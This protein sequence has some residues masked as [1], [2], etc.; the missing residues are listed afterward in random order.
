MSEPRREA[1]GLRRALRRDGLRVAALAGAIVVVW[2]VAYGRTNLAAWLVPV[3]Y[4][5]DSWHTLAVLKAAADGHVVP[6]HTL[7]VDELN[8]PYGAGWNGFLRQH[9]LQY[10]FAGRLAR[11]I[12][13]FPASNL[14][15]LL[16]PMLA[17]VSLFAVS[18][19][20]RARPEWALAAACVFAFAPFLFYRSLPHLTL[21]FYWPIPI[22]ILVV[23][24]AFGRRAIVLG[25]RRFWIS[26][27][28][29]FACGLQNIYFAG[30]LAQFLALAALVQCP[31][32]RRLGG[33][34]APLTLL[35]IL[36]TSLLLDNLN[37]LLDAAGNGGGL[38]GIVRPY[39]NLERFALKPLELVLPPAGSGLAPWRPLSE[40]YQQ[41]ALYRGE[42]GSAYLGLAGIAALGWLAV[43][44]A[45]GF[46]R[47]P[48]A[49]VPAAFLAVSWIV[50]YSVIGGINGIL[51]LLGFIWLRATNRYSI[52]ILALVLLWA[53]VRLSRRPQLSRRAS[54]LTA[55]TVTAVALCDQIPWHAAETIGPVTAATSSDGLL[56]RNLEAGLPAGAM[57]FQLPVVDFPEGTRVRGT[58]DYDHFRPYLFSSHLRFSYGA[59]KGRP[60]EAWQ[61]RA[62]ALPP[63]AM[64]EALER[65]GFSGL[66][67]NRRAYEDG[68][69]DLREQLAAGGRREAWESPDH[70]F[71]F[72]R[73]RPVATPNLPDTVIP[74]ESPPAATPS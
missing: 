13:L 6:L 73:L 7:E 42:I 37:L 72:I 12:G 18:R 49:F 57:I 34:L 70:D 17:G 35:A 8:A 62:E 68:G 55:L 11:V 67:V 40:A 50:A 24:W 39:G 21:T 25:S 32:S 71:L 38:E 54:A 2:C 74:P 3:D 63:E 14:V 53:A 61:H 26:A 45:A 44:A 56:V 65:I 33:V 69:R 27:A 31:R 1:A 52:W 60:R 36:L 41:S 10:W 43:S 16:A 22:A 9:K 4:S 46:F 28:I 64:A 15:L 66:L 29:A 59:D 58:V 5:G 19:Y 48:K 47:R 51:G 20:F 30:L 23:T